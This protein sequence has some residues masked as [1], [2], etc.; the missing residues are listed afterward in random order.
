M[1][2][3]ERDLRE[4]RAYLSSSSPTAPPSSTMPK[5][6][7]EE[8]EEAVFLIIIGCEG[9]VAPEGTRRATVTG[10]EV[11]AQARTASLNEL[12]FGRG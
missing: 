1:S 7:F 3:D 10:S 6:A 12:G 8:E 5:A 2:A 9:G 11:T 4:R